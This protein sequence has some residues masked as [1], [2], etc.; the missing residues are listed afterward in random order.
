MGML[1][2]GSSL[3]SYADGDTSNWVWNGTAHSSTS[4]GPAL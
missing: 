4:T 1:T 3:T 2:E